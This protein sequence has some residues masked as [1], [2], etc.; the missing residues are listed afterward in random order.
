MNYITNNLMF[1]S[2]IGKALKNIHTKPSVKKFAKCSI[3]VMSDIH[4]EFTDINALENTTY[5]KPTA[6]N[7]IVAGDVGY[8]HTA[9]YNKFFEYAAKN[10]TNVLYVIGNHEYYNSKSKNSVWEPVN[11]VDIDKQI[12]KVIDKYPNVHLL[13]NSK[14]VIDGVEFIGSTLWSQP[15]STNSF[16]DFVLIY[17]E[18]QPITKQ[19]VKEWNEISVKFIEESLNEV[20]GAQKCV[21]THFMPLQNADIPNTKYDIDPLYDSYFGNYLYNLI[22]K[23]NVWVSGHTHQSF[24]FVPK[25]TNTLWICNPY[26]YPHEQPHIDHDNMIIDIDANIKSN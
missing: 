24:N 10:W 15:L 6:R 8:P 2:M 7:L 22:K 5:F 4:F 1:V 11:K 20:N 12:K 3:Q 17:H 9:E 13:D 25:N 19:I 23:A 26:G 18:N 16:N 21:I 14:I